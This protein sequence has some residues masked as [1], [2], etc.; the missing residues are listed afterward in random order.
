VRQVLWAADA[1]GRALVATTL[2]VIGA[3]L[4]VSVVARFFAG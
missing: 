4:A 1:A 2:L 3:A